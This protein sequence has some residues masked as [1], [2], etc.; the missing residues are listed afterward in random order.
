MVAFFENDQM[1]KVLLYLEGEEVIIEM[2]REMSMNQQRYYHCQGIL[3]TI[4]GRKKVPRLSDLP[5]S[6]FGE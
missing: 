5:L 4:H 3:G 2:D 1:S 6:K